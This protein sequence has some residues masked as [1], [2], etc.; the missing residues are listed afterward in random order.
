MN[1]R[2]AFSDRVDL[3][4]YGNTCTFSGNTASGRPFTYVLPLA[5]V[6]RWIEGENI[7]TCF[8][9]LTATEREIM[10][11]GYDTVNDHA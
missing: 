8:P 3:T 5:A 4:L 6:S 10:M 9:Y 2:Y 1:G 7:E 11:T